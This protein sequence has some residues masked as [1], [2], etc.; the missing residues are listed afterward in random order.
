MGAVEMLDMDSHSSCSGGDNPPLQDVRNWASYVEGYVSSS[1]R[2]DPTVTEKA[3]RK[4]TDPSAT[5]HSSVKKPVFLQRNLKQ[6]ERR[7]RKDATNQSRKFIL[8]Y[9]SFIE[10]YSFRLEY[11]P[12]LLFPFNLS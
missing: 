1:S 8:Y 2:M 9:Y 4:N 10:M 7:R 5:F 6:W 12:L 11:L 3:R